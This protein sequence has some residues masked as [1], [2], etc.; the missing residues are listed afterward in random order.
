MERSN[1]LT[2]IDEKATV[3][4]NNIFYDIF[5]HLYWFKPFYLFHFYIDLKK[6]FISWFKKMLQK[7]YQANI[8]Y[9]NWL[10]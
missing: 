6:Y 1:S 10:T 8:K 2:F 4:W 7:N 5:N 3:Q 9:H